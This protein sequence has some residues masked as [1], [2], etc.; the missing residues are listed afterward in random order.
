MEGAVVDYFKAPQLYSPCFKISNLVTLFNRKVVI[1][2]LGV[3]M[4]YIYT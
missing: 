4:H 3:L 2:L 1:R